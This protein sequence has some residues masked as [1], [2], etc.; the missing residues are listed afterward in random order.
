MG[1]AIEETTRRRHGVTKQ[2]RHERRRLRVLSQDSFAELVQYF[3]KGNDDDDFTDSRSSRS[4]PVDFLDRF[5]ASKIGHVRSS[6]DDHGRPAERDILHGKHGGARTRVVR[7]I[8]HGE[9]HVLKEYALDKT[10]EQQVDKEVKKLLQLQHPNIVK[11]T[12]AFLDGPGGRNYCLQMPQYKCNLRTWAEKEYKPTMETHIN[13]QVLKGLLMGALRAVMKVHSN[14]YVHNDIKQSNVFLTFEDPPTA[15]LADFEFSFAEDGPD[16]SSST[17]S[18]TSGNGGG[19]PA[20]L[21]PE[22]SIW[23]QK[24][25]ASADMYAVGVLILLTVIPD[26]I[27][28]AETTR[29]DS[30]NAQEI[31]KSEAGRS[32]TLLSR[33]LEELLRRLLTPE[34]ECVRSKELY[35]PLAR[36]SVLDSF[37]PDRM[38]FGPDHSVEKG[39]TLEII[40]EKSTDDGVFLQFAV[41]GSRGSPVAQRECW[42]EQQRPDDYIYFPAQQKGDR[43]RPIRFKQLT[44]TGGNCVFEAGPPGLESWYDTVR[45]DASLWR[46]TSDAH[47]DNHAVHQS[48]RAVDPVR[49]SRLEPNRAS[50]DLRVTGAVH[51]GATHRNPAPSGEL[52]L[53]SSGDKKEYFRCLRP[54]AEQV[55]MDPYFTSD[56]SMPAHWKKERGRFPKIVPVA[57]D[58]LAMGAIKRMVAPARPSELG[59][60]RDAQAQRAWQQV[61]RERAIHPSKRNIEV[62]RCWKLQNEQLWNAYHAKKE[63][64]DKDLIDGPP[65]HPSVEG[66]KPHTVPAGGPWQFGVRDAL[67]AG[68]RETSVGAVDSSVNEVM[69]I[70]GLPAA[71]VGPVMETGLEPRLAG[72]N[73][74]NFFG[75][76]TYLAEDIEKADMYVKTCD[77]G[78][79]QSEHDSLGKQDSDKAAEQQERNQ[80]VQKLHEQLYPNHDHPGEVYYALVC[81]TL[82]GYSV[83]TK[84]PDRLG[85]GMLYQ[86]MDEGVLNEGKASV[87]HGP[88]YN[89]LEA[90]PGYGP[91]RRHQVRYH[92]LIGELGHCIAR[93]REFV[94]FES[95]LVYPEY[96]IAYQRAEREVE[97]EPEPEP[98]LNKAL[99]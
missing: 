17:D 19:T 63:M 98:E 44:D 5:E 69:L 48:T 91:G 40:K 88:G 67:A 92:T 50:V 16:K 95:N 49:A 28:E 45:S 53:A 1:G 51:T 6:Y 11:L 57:A 33:E 35:T 71:A 8:L 62:V 3:A 30:K 36:T 61:P 85:P 73:A 77:T 42:V 47:V 96:L 81:R 65:L 27:K 68:A 18:S 60:G 43:F 34:Y 84:G 20:Y 39:Q 82:L 79:K 58:S 76:G 25:T 74:G 26:Q 66:T 24:G 2:L 4:G 22:R 94:V 46:T 29:P 38:P 52:C 10:E 78:Y 99:L 23:K 97:P 41:N 13:R 55:L 37:G 59:V 89:L 32:Q 83:R 72:G 90:L 14:G 31:L 70:H 80:S 21:A 75:N 86:P 15:V 9:L 12:A 64:V 7:V 56:K 54:T 87:F 93:F